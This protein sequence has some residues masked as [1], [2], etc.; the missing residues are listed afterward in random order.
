LGADIFGGKKIIQ[1]N[2]GKTP[3]EY[4]SHEM[5]IP[6]LIKIWTAH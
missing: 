1:G 4:R 5:R 6:S 3:K 2:K